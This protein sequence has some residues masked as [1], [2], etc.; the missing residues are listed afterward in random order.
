METQNTNQTEQNNQ[1]PPVNVSPLP[2]SKKSSS[3]KKWWGIV[4]IVVLL[5]VVGI[6]VFWFK[7]SN[8][9][10]MSLESKFGRTEKIVSHVGSGETFLDNGVMGSFLT[11]SFTDKKGQDVWFNLNSI[12]DND[13]RSNLKEGE[14]VTVYYNPNNPYDA[15]IYFSD[16]SFVENK[17]N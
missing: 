2:S 10:I 12:M 3:K 7:Y 15:A 11:I 6:F 1:V 13:K 9:K 16:G 14:E 17:S 5:I 8:N 4:S